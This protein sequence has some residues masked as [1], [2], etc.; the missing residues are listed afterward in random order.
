MSRLIAAF[1]FRWRYP[2]SALCVLG[3]L[4]SIPRANITKIDNDI[5]AWFSK[6]DPVYQDYERFRAEFGGTRNADRRARGALAEALF[7]AA[8]LAFIERITGDIERVDTVQRVEQPGHRD[9]GRRRARRPGSPAVSSSSSQSGGPGAPSRRR[10]LEDELIRGDLVSEDGTVTAIIVSFDEDRID[11][12]RGGVIQ[13]IHDIVD[14]GLPPGIRA[15]LQR[16]P[17]DQRDLQPHHARQPAEVHAA[18]PALHASRRSTSRSDRGRKTLLA[19]VAVGDQRPVDARPLL[20]DGLQLQRPRQH[21]RARS[22]SCWRSPT[23]CTS[24]STG[25]R[26]GAT[27]TSSRRSRRPSRTWRRRCSAPA[28]RRRSACCRWRRATSSRSGRSASD[29]RSASWSTS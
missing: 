3:A 19:L 29:R 16:Q 21:D 8:T 11:D 22:S 13:Q 15:L 14:P 10:A 2:L 9:G 24:C 18:D 26:S 27:A 5:T 28:P 12:V 1:I 17:R 4:V 23:T 20:A 25:T 7:S 6:S